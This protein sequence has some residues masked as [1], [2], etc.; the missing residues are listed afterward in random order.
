M[1]SEKLS[2][3]YAGDLKPADAWTLLGSEPTAQLV[4][5]RTRAEWNFVGRPDLSGLGRQVHFVEWLD[6]PAGTP[7]PDFVAK[8]SAALGGDKNAPVLFLCRSGARSR[9]A[10]T[11]MTAAGYVRAYNIAEGFEGDPDDNYHRGTK[12]GWKAAGLPWIQ[13]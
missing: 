6:F 11:A 3:G 7:D 12:N 4:D 8:A 10:A 1:A 13:T 2:S 5:V 9:A